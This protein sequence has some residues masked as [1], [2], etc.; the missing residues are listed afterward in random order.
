MPIYMVH[1]DFQN[2][3]PVVSCPSCIQT[4]THISLFSYRYWCALLERGFVNHLVKPLAKPLEGPGEAPGK[5]P[6]KAS[7]EAP[8][9]APS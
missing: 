9:K 5:A 1:L 3:A 7:S 4:Y 2:V 8:S 6:S